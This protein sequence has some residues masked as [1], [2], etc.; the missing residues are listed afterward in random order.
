MWPWTANLSNFPIG[1]RNLALDPASEFPSISANEMEQFVGKIIGDSNPSKPIVSVPTALGELK[2][3]PGLVRGFWQ[4]VLKNRKGKNFVARLAEANLDWRFGVKPMVGDVKKLLRFSEEVAKLLRALRR[5]QDIGAMYRRVLLRRQEIP[6]TMVYQGYLNTVGYCPIEGQRFTRYT[7]TVWG[8]CRWV[9]MSGFTIPDT[10]EELLKLLRQICSGRSI[11][12]APSTAWELIPWSWL[13]DWFANIQDFLNAIRT[14]FML[15][16]EGVCVM[17]TMIA[18]SQY[19]ITS[20]PPWPILT[21]EGD[22]EEYAVRKQR[23]VPG[24]SVGL[25]ASVPSLTEGQWSILGSLAILKA[26]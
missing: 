6:L 5:L 16:P 21:I 1:Y 26:L 13:A 9:P 14:D 10:D 3:V 20:I 17:R 25:A 2:D 8:T 12:D 19:N 23:F 22:Y 11:W 24:S 15:K 18:R 7:E 4:D